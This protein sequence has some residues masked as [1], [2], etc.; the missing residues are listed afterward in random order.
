MG[1]GSGFLLYGVESLG[2]PLKFI[3]E[4]PL[5]RH[6]TCSL[7]NCCGFSHT[8]VHPKGAFNVF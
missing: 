1:Q 5:K 7:D 4:F 8:R 2:A 3:T 6:L